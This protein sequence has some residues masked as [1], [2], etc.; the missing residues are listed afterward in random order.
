MM[1]Y[2][3]RGFTLLEILI[4]MGLMGL[5]AALLV[6][7]VLSGT[8]RYT[9]RHHT[10]AVSAVMR[11]ARG[12]AI[13][14]QKETVVVFDLDKKSYQLVG[15]S[16]SKKLDDDIDLTVFTSQTEVSAEGKKAGIRF[17][18]DGGSS[19]GRVTLA[20]NEN[21]RAIDVVWMTGQMNILEETTHDN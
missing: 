3:H 12:R 8:D 4:V 13:A 7:S 1:R 18:P 5:M 11:L 21:Y 9:L 15:E 20:L 2:F 6:P 16:S 19:G 17:Y 10:R 14:E